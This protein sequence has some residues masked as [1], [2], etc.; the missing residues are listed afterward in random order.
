M[1]LL[2]EVTQAERQGGRGTTWRVNPKAMSQYS[3]MNR[4]FKAYL[5]HSFR[6]K[7]WIVREK[8]NMERWTSTT[9]AVAN[10]A[11][12]FPDKYGGMAEI[13]ILGQVS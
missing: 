11:V 9:P 3:K 1:Q 13:F 12:F 6:D 2:D 7:D 5:T 8:T 4:F 10:T